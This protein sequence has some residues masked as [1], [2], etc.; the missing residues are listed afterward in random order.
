MGIGSERGTRD[1]LRK[2]M[3]TGYAGIALLSST[4]C[5]KVLRPG[6]R[7]LPPVS[8]PHRVPPNRKHIQEHLHAVAKHVD[9]RGRR[10]RPA[11]RNLHRFQS[12]VARKIEQL[13]VEPESLNPLLRKNNFAALAP[14]RLESAL[15]IHERQQQYSAHNLVKNDSGKFAKARF[16]HRD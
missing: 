16:M 7:L 4:L 13:R 1:G 5:D 8:P 2:A 10:V 9:L 3:R 15:R 12:M 14:K 6:T 11:H